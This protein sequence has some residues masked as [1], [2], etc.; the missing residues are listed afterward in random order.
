MSPLF[1]KNS[2]DFYILYVYFVS[3]PTL[4]MMHFCITQCMYWTPLWYGII[5][6]VWYSMV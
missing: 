3:S 1:S 2:P 6:M 4:T 5:G